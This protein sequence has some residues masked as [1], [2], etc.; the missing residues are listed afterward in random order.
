MSKPENNPN[1]PRLEDFAPRKKRAGKILKHLYKAYP[2]AERT[3][4]D[5]D[6]DPLEMVV[7]TI[8]SAQCTDDQVNL[9][10][11]SL[12]KRYRTARD[13]ANA[14]VK[15]LEALIK[16]TGFYHNKTKNIIACAKALIENF[17]GAVPREMDKLITLPGIGRKTAN[18]VKYAVWGDNDGIAVDTHVGRLSR[19]LGLSI[20][21][22]AVKVELDLLEVTPEKSRGDFS[23]M[24]I[25]HGREVCDSRKPACDKCVLKDLCPS[26]F[27]AENIK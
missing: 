26:A 21:T 2:I 7:A 6:E 12:F 17:G 27:H 25:Q 24:L 20:Q 8:L 13:Y 10:T 15:E 9:V 3:A 5:H 4:L 23:W 11:P 14:D 16:P 1:L 22:D 18:V 19:R